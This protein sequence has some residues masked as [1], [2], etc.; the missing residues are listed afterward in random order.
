MATG[1]TYYWMR[2]KESFLNSDTVDFFMSQPNGA[3]YVVL[4]QA[5]CL[6]TINTEGRLSRQIGD[7]IIPFDIE[8]IRRD[9]KW[10][11]ADTIRVALEYYK[12]FGLIY[13]DVD[14][15]LVMADHHNLVGK[16][17]DYADQKKAQRIKNAEKPKLLADGGVDNVH[18]DVH[19]EIRYKS[20]EIRDKSLEEEDISTGSKEPVCRTSDVRRV[21][22]A[23]ND[24][25]LTQVT[26]I[27]ADTN[28]GRMLKARIRENG[29]D[30]V[31][32]SIENVKNSTFL[33][34]QNNRGFEATFDWFVKPNNF[35]KV[36]EG[37]YTDKKAAETDWRTSEAYQIAEYLARE[38][39]KDNPGRAWPTDAEMQRQA[40]VLE[41]LHTQ[42][43]VEWDTIDN[44][45]Y[46]ALNSQWWS[47][48]VQS[49]HDL[50]WHFNEIYEDMTKEQGAV[51]EE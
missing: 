9:C 2:L 35:L 37:N 26:K 46:F 43:G 23:W 44:V 50:K 25:G 38:K 8:K 4:Y 3:N 32:K 22:E 41:E 40:A 24:T 30:G 10:F 5:L 11:S 29:V 14:G 47:K 15:T 45:L 49:A 6:K 13:Q 28:R 48:K 21:I 19:T 34:G 1:K 33:K 20:I 7:I 39:A 17:T 12:R 51:K 31:L 42:S 36:L 27:T 18:S 16:T